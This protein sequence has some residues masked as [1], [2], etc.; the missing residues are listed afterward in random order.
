[1][2][3]DMREV[4]RTRRLGDREERGS[5]ACAHYQA[6]RGCKVERLKSI[7]FHLEV[8]GRMHLEAARN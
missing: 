2:G 5:C 7:K 1:M 3:R 4:Q 6:R 8:N